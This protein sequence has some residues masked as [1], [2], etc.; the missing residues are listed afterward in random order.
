MEVLYLAVENDVILFF[1]PSHITQHLQSLDHSFF[2]P[3][4]IY[5]RQVLNSL[6]HNKLNRK[7]S[8]LQFESCLNAAW[9]KAVTVGNGTSGFSTTG[10]YPSNPQA[11]P[12]YAFALSDGS[13]ND[14]ALA[15]TSGACNMSTPEVAS[16]S[17]ASGSRLSP[18]VAFTNIEHGIL[19]SRSN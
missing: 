10:I 8:R 12:Q 5:C 1:L 11:V 17:R 7:V 9:S 19:L 18:S 4:K 16:T 15:S 2:K 3:L 14:T 13:S 6:I